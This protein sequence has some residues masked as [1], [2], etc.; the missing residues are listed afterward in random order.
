ML[1]KI[2]KDK[3]VYLFK[4]GLFLVIC[5][6]ILIFQ[7][8]SSN[9]QD[10]FPFNDCDNNFE[11][12]PHASIESDTH[13]FEWSS[14]WDG[15][16]DDFG[17]GIATDSSNNIYFAGVTNSYGEGGYD[18][19]L[20]KYDKNGNQIWNQT[21]G[22]T[23]DENCNAIAT[24]SSDNIYLVGNTNSFGFT[25]HEL[26]LI[27]FNSSGS[28]LWNRTWGQS[29]Y[30]IQ[31]PE[32]G[33]AIVIDTN[34]DIYVGGY[35]KV[36]Y[37]DDTDMI[38]VK[39]NKDGY[40][41][42][43]VTKDVGG[44]ERIEGMAL[45]SS[46]DIFVTG[47]TSY[48]QVAWEWDEEEHL[49]A[50]FS[51]SGV[52]QWHKMWGEFNRHDRLH[53]IVIDS[54]DYIYVS[55]T[56]TATRLIKLDSGG[57][58][59]WTRTWGSGLRYICPGMV[60]DSSDDI[61]LTGWVNNVQGSNGIEGYLLKYNSLGDY[62]WHE[63][64]GYTLAYGI[65]L[66]SHE[67]I[68]IGGSG[69][70]KMKLVKFKAPTKLEINSPFEYQPFGIESPN[71]NITVLN[72]NIHQ[73]WYSLNDGINYTITTDTGKI[74]QTEW[75]QCING[76]ISIKFF[77]N[78]S[79]SPIVSKE[80]I[81]RKGSIMLPPPVLNP[82]TIEP[83]YDGLA[84]LSW[85]NEIGAS[86]YY[87]FRAK[88][89]IESIIGMQPFASTTFPNYTDTLTIPRIYYYRIIAG[90]FTHNSTQSNC[91]SIELGTYIPPIHI[92]DS[93]PSRNWQ[94]MAAEKYWC[95]GTGTFNDPYTIKDIVIKRDFS[96]DGILI[97]KSSAYFVIRNCTIL[98]SVSGI[99]LR[100]VT[101]GMIKNNT[102]E[103][104]SNHG[105]FLNY[106]CENNTIFDNI[107]FNNSG[108]GIYIYS[109]STDNIIDSNVIVEN[110]H[111]GITIRDY[112]D[113]NTIINNQIVENGNTGIEIYT[114][115]DNNKILNNEILD[116]VNDGITI[117]WGSDNNL[118]SNNNIVGNGRYG[119][120]LR[121]AS[122]ENNVSRNLIA[123]SGSHGILVDRSE[124]IW[125][126]LDCLITGNNISFS[127]G[128]GIHLI[129]GRYLT[130]E[131]NDIS[132][133]PYG[134]YLESDFDF[135]MFHNNTI[136]DNT[137][138]GVYAA[139]DDGVSND[140]NSF[141]N[142]YFIGNTMNARDSVSNGNDWSKG[143]L[144]NFWDDY[145]GTDYNDDGI[146]D[147]PYEIG[148][149]NQTLDNYPI[150][151]DG[152]D[153]SPPIINILSP[154]ENEIF[155]FESPQ[156]E[157][158]ID[159]L[160]TNSSWYTIL[161]GSHNYT[162]YSTIDQIDQT[163]WDELGNGSVIIRFYAN[164]SLGNIG[165]SDVMVYKDILAP[166][167]NINNPLDYE[168]FGLAVPSFDLS[169]MEGNLHQTWY[170]L[171][172]GINYTFV[173]LNNVIDHG[174]WG[175]C[176][177]GTVIIRFYANDSMGNIDFEDIIVRKDIIKPV[178]S[179]QNPTNNELFGNNTIDF[180]IQVDEPNSDTTWYNLNSGPDY[181]VTSLTGT[182]DSPAWQA[183]GTGLITIRFYSNDTVGNVNF[184][185]VTIRKDSTIPSIVITSPYP[186]ELFG[187]KSF[188]FEL[189]ISE[190]NLMTSWYTI[191]NGGSHYF[192]GTTDIID[193]FE[194]ESCQNG[195]VILTFYAN[196]TM[197]NKGSSII[198]VRKD[199]LI[200]DFTIIS[201]VIDELFGIQP[202]S[203]ELSIIEPNLDTTWCILNGQFTYFFSGELGTVDS[204]IWDL[205]DDGIIN[206][207]FYVNDTVGNLQSKEI[208]IRKD[209]TAPETLL[210]FIPHTEPNT[211][212]KTTLLTLEAIDLGDFGVLRIEY[213]INDSSW[214]IYNGPFDLSIYRAGNYLI[215]YRAI[216]NGGNIEII[217]SY[218]IKL[219]ELTEPP[220]PPDPTPSIPGYNL[221]I[222]ILSFA[223][224]V[225]FMIK[226][227]N[228]KVKPRTI[229][230]EI[231]ERF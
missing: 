169:I 201:P 4:F 97:E 166:I 138:Y 226:Y 54:S 17:Y 40:Q 9:N 190:P 173:G 35:T 182:I 37:A 229:K 164:D 192:T 181:I 198:S 144:G 185:Q 42:W 223:V 84:K 224:I 108:K 159:S 219:I 117:L 158:S 27:K 167:I 128:S 180:E 15:P 8:I 92:D 95:S 155:S 174:A 231:D 94:K 75:E 126:N 116:N 55:G 149:D 7:C 195:T 186:N 83:E 115:N 98:N 230:G 3:R 172:N 113:R 21:W 32:Y 68:Y 14:V 73:K 175:V 171:N 38:I 183:C 110:H 70:G 162:L 188:S 22:G 178:I 26:C 123:Y 222:I 10:I 203:F 228:R 107:I 176:G 142:N 105:I 6:G 86:Q 13:T 102:I 53:S 52:F 208:S 125:K 184:Q 121:G 62:Q 111:D 101:N 165:F 127:G 28:Q 12:N 1:L 207:K 130:C 81:V 177:N 71:Y 210:I 168:L 100:Q 163:I 202:F 196:D 57:N 211:I 50:K 145:H 133:N 46:G 43:N 112:S 79:L 45:D 69:G 76:T 36:R 189:S 61:Y 137:N 194:W 72:S 74:N 153:L 51:S 114:D 19:V 59:L 143:I 118:A 93:N 34:D 67:N 214:F 85:S 154:F 58:V 197:G 20:I 148:G 220:S 216:D 212:N 225:I 104:N 141:Y 39:Y 150:W 135:S 23:G 106:L 199:K 191:N 41:L 131:S 160:Y 65:N 215:Y 11:Q 209:T 109:S 82:I 29:Y 44:Y 205:C 31:Y 152:D 56:F 66:D 78:D 49:L 48:W 18:I 90:N 129:D 25:T 151:E 88:S 147:I 132:N 140:H 213:A 99:Q 136:H 170:S 206:I 157:I 217:Q 96:V 80:V 24:D 5:V 120:W 89:Y 193:S 16:S 103:K 179:I 200:P 161:G 47:Q 64:A 91:Q 60:I 156:F 204:A 33:R 218:L 122:L 124:P 187:N 119:L 30:T 63:F 2:K 134:I 221:S 146:G 87:I 139:D 77:V 227:L